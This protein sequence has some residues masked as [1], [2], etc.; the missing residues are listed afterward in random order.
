M[1]IITALL[2]Q[3]I[4][5]TAMAASGSTDLG[6]MNSSS[7]SS[8]AINFGTATLTGL[9]PLANG[10]NHV[11]LSGTGGTSQVLKQTSV[12]GDISVARLACADL[13][14]AAASCATD[15]TS[16]TNIS[17]GTL[18]IARGGTG[19]AAVT[20]TPTASTFSGW[21]A[22]V[23][24]SANSFIPGYTTTATAAGTT[25]LTVASTETQYFTGS[26]TQTVKLPVVSTL[27]LNQKFTIVNNSSGI[28]TVQSSGANNIKAMAAS[29][30]AIYTCILTSGTTAASWNVEL[31]QLQSFVT[32]LGVTSGGT[33]T[34]TQF[35]QNRVV[36][37][38]ASGVYS[39]QSNFNYDAS[40]LYLTSVNANTLNI[41]AMFGTVYNVFAVRSLGGSIDPN[42]NGVAFMNFYSPDG[43]AP[44][45]NGGVNSHAGIN[46]KPGS[47]VAI[48]AQGGNGQ[49]GMVD[50][51]TKAQDDDT[52]EP[53]VKL[54]INQAG[55]LLSSG[56]LA[57]TITANCGTSPSIAGTDTNGRLNVGTGGT[58]TT[59]T[60][61]FGTAWT[62]APSC[63]AATESTALTIKAKASTSTLIITSATPFTASDLITYICMGYQ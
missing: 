46:P 7:G 36:F 40:N 50:F 43:T 35:T 53:T 13:S 57:P 9:V 37:A 16:A 56:G 4:V 23:N 41:S 44:A 34:A 6:P 30:V 31:Y 32:P 3:F 24:F 60:I 55:H 58:A 1:K 18:A 33:G 12:G 48:V 51:A 26:T 47:W 52:S 62:T 14:N 20:T 59:C 11:D 54:T 2:A 27:V 49:Q 15:T 38:G 42:G 21:D 19:V 25:T 29:T 28:V 39:Q 61:T 45:A 17:A 8:T 63:V 5:A 22:N 10:G